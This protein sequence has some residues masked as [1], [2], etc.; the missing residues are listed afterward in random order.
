[1]Q[2]EFNAGC[3]QSLQQHG[4]LLGRVARISNNDRETVGRPLDQAHDHPVADQPARDAA[5]GV[6]EVGGELWTIPT[7]AL[8]HDG[9]RVLRSSRDLQSI[10]DHLTLVSSDAPWLQSRLQV[11]HF[12]GQRRL[13]R[14]TLVVADKRVQIAVAG[15]KDVGDLVQLLAESLPG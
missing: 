7:P 2:V 13:S 14:H 15:V 6:V 5:E 10:R 4:F 11:G 1:L 12:F 3:L 9:E 8:M